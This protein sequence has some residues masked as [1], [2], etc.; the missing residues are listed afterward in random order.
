M[1]ILFGLAVV[2]LSILFWMFVALFTKTWLY[3]MAAVGLVSLAMAGYRYSSNVDMA[4]RLGFAPRSF[5]ATF[6]M[7]LA[8]QVVFGAIG[9]V[10]SDRN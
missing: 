2:G 5:L 9:K 3:Q 8:V 7:V 10:I 1:G 4:D 6:L